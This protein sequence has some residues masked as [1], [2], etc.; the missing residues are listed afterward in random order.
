MVLERIR[1]AAPARLYVA[2]DGA[3]PHVPDDDARCR[4][5]RELVSLVD[6]PC[7]IETLFRQDNL[8]CGRGVSEAISWFFANEEAGIILEDDIL[9]TQSFFEFC[10]TMLIRYKDN[11][12][13]AMIAGSCFAPSHLFE[14][15][16]YKFSTYP[17]IWGW[18]S[19]RRA[20][21]HYD[22]DMR[23]WPDWERASGLANLANGDR[24]FENHWRTIF[25]SMYQCE[26][27]VTWDYQ[28]LFKN[29]ECGFKTVIPCRSVVSNIGFD[30]DATHVFKVPWYVRK[31]KPNEM[32]FPLTHP[33]NID[34]DRLLDRHLNKNVFN[35]NLSYK[36]RY[37]VE[38]AV[39]AGAVRL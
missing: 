34:V 2:V 39:G 9:P 4:E 3:R 14:H 23:S 6:W 22:Y 25:E 24:F 35:V 7:R 29:W 10:D 30:V 18:A 5:V 36:L 15:F 31:F 8:G 19:W 16:S 26:S 32:Q 13:I 28:W 12:Q 20:W 17:A 37:F 33:S 27:K 38:K 11:E 1:L 21:R